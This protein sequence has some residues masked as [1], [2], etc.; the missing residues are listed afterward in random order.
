MI[1][2]ENTELYRYEIHSLLKAFYPQETVK[3]FVGEPDVRK[4]PE[5]AFLRVNFLEDSVEMTILPEG[6]PEHT[7]ETGSKEESAPLTC[8]RQA[9]EGIRF[10]Q[11]SA[12]NSSLGRADRH[13][14]H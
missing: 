3:V 4:Y 11:K 2:I 14:S 6:A 13:P 7:E 5:P 8:I 9:P 1:A 12:D 10:D